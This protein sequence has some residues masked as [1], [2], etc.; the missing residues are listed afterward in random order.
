[1]AMS[2]I[3]DSCNDLDTKHWAEDGAVYP[4][5]DD[6]LK[7]FIPSASTRGH[8]SCSI[9]GGRNTCLAGRMLALESSVWFCGSHTL[10]GLLISNPPRRGHTI[11]VNMS[12]CQRP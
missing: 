6:S 8:S 11:P 1:M 10:P 5:A 12:A 7:D 3:L 9:S 4:V 2:R